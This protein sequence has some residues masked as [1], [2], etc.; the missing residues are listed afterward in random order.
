MSEYTFTNALGFSLAELA[1]MVNRS[2]EQSYLPLQQTALEL[3]NYCQYNNMDLGN[4][5][6][7]FDG[8]SFVGCS[9]LATRGQRGWLGGFGIVPQYRGQGAGKALLT[10]QLAVARALG[11]AQIQLEVPLQTAEA[12]RL[13]ESAGFKS[14]RGVLD[15]LLATDAL[16]QPV[17]TANISKREPE[18]MM[19]WLLQG[20]Q[21]AWTRERINLQIKGGDA[22]VLTRADGTSTVMM[23]RRRGSQGEKVQLY[24]VALTEPS[25]DNFALMLR[26]AAAGATTISIHNEPE[27]T[28]LHLAC[29]ALGFAEEHRYHEMAIEL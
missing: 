11:L 23:Y 19:D 9:M 13:G 28:A 29:T 6:V 17:S 14:R 18:A 22:V 3:A 4:T 12:T 16:P 25:S 2:Y 8:D 10:R 5:V 21:P 20:Q 15:L 7:M 1:A 26:H 24:A 27:G